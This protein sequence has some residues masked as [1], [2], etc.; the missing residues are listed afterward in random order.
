MQPQLI[1][2]RDPAGIL[3][4][5]VHQLDTERTLQQQI[6][7]AM[8]GGG[9]EC[10]LIIN[11]ERVDPHTDPRL[12]EP[13][14]AGDVVV[15]AHRPAGDPITWIAIVSALLAVASYAAIPKPNET[16]TATDS[17]NN[18]L[19]GQSNVARAYQAIPDVYGR[20]RVWPDLI[21]PSD[22]RY[23]GNVKVVTEWLCV[24]RGAGDITG[25]KFADTPL[26]D[27]R[28]ASWQA[29]A[30]GQ[31]FELSPGVVGPSIPA[32]P[33]PTPPI[34]VPAG[35]PEALTTR[36]LDVSETFAVP[37]A[38]GVDLAAPGQDFDAI[39]CGPVTGFFE[40]GG[41]STFEFED[42]PQFDIL[43]ASTL[44][45]TISSA[46]FSRFVPPFTS[47]IRNGTL[48][49]I[50]PSSPGR[51]NLVFTLNAPV[52][53]GGLGF[54][55]S[56]VPDGTPQSNSSGEYTLPIADANRIR[57]NMAFPRGLRG[58]VSVLVEWWKI[59]AAGA[60][61]IGTRESLLQAYPRNSFDA[62]FFT[63]E[64]EP[65]GGAGRYK[66]KF[67]RLSALD[68]DG[69][70]A[71]T[72]EDVFA[73]RNFPI[74]DLVAQGVTVIRVET[75]ATTQTT[76]IRERKFNLVWQRRVRALDADTLSASRNAFRAMAHLWTISGQ[77]LAEL[78]TAAMQ[79][80][81]DQLGE[82]SPLLRFDGSLDDA[83]MSLE[84]RM[85]LIANHARCVFWRDGTKWTVTRDQARSVPELQ[86]DYRNLSASGQAVTNESFHLP[87]SRDG[88]EVEFVDEATQSRKAY[89]RL[90]ITSGTPAAGAV[91]N[92]EK[93]QLLGC[94][95]VEQATNRAHLEA[96]KLLFQR[97][98]VTE[99]ALGD[100]QQLG[101]LSLVRY[102]DP[103]D[104]AGDDGLQAGEVLAIAGSVLTLSEPPDFKSQASGRIQFTGADG[105]LLGPAV[106]CTPVAGLPYRV[107]LASVPAGL[108]VADGVTAQ[109]GSRY[110][111]GVGLT[112]AEMESA[113]L[114]TVTEPR[115]NGDGT[116]SVAMV[117]YDQRVY[118]F[119]ANTPANTIVRGGVAAAAASGRA[120]DIRTAGRL[121][122]GAGVGAATAS[123]RTAGITVGTVTTISGSVGT[124]AA[125]GRPAELRFGGP[126]NGASFSA[127]A[128]SS[129]I[130]SATAAVRFKAAGAVAQSTDSA[131]TS[132]VDYSAWHAGAV[133]GS[134]WVRFTEVSA[135]GGTLTGA[136]G[137][138]LSMASDRT[139]SFESFAYASASVTWQIA[140]DAAG[141]DIRATGS[142]TLTALGN[143]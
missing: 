127:Y 41:T 28:G 57:W 76:G 126:I 113:G 81:S 116:W 128:E 56:V 136:G 95:T 55:C 75:R 130:G 94:T 108:Y 43:R 19:T 141:A 62:Q 65:A 63:N 16:P 34:G 47:V 121:I 111:F 120:A 69:N 139:V 59:D 30:P 110:A 68:A 87:G 46:Q 93:F 82:D 80:I 133:T 83:D 119:D 37:S 64:V 85:Q 140:A 58:S 60:E 142:I 118:A 124:A 131:G 38:N 50:A 79:A 8:P 138:W 36:L 114:Y 97:T 32:P 12:D 88:V 23:I 72:L 92:P 134:W 104:F 70:G 45:L 14:R 129:G 22:V 25:V 27:I 35:Y 44:P 40:S 100:A 15:V 106:V 96:R 2:L 52:G 11:A 101:P 9:A 4:R 51:V 123:G 125:T 137:G 86:L 18:R 89:V 74:R 39:S 1:L 7:A 13:P 115:P 102:V 90:N 3:G 122:I 5:E 17:P 53:F 29:F 103:A 31:G 135:A 105:R 49:D 84:E 61:I 132:F 10:E 24:S 78:D 112:A 117:N 71:A 6:E 107:T 54:F 21:Q 66:I 91:A 48:T 26:D 73:V 99:T 67:T 98:S 109:L 20:R 33:V 143:V 77:P 42:G